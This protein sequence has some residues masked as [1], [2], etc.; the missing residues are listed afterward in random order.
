MA[1]YFIQAADGPV[2]I[3]RAVDV[4]A[5]LRA[6]QTAHAKELKLLRVIEGGAVEEWECHHAFRNAHIRGEWFEYHDD[7]LTFL[8]SGRAKVAILRD[9]RVSCHHD[10]LVSFLRASIKSGPLPQQEVARRMGYTPSAL[11]RKLAQ[12]PDDSR[13]FTLDDLEKYVDVTGDKKPILYLVEKYL[14]ETDEAALLRQIEALQAQLKGA[15]RK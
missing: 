4:P 7:M 3:G 1:V 5:R 11:S 13:R 2:K 8:P 14:A 15:K 10:S 6:L 9:H 12:N